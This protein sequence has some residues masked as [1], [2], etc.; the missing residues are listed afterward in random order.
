ML[1]NCTVFEWIFK[2]I[3]EKFKGE[4][5]YGFSVAHLSALA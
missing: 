3:Y 2:E 4:L 5:N 1:L